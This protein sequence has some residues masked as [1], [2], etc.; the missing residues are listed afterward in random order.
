VPDEL[1]PTIRLR[2]QVDLE[3]MDWLNFLAALR[4]S[5]RVDIPES[6]YEKLVTLDGLFVYLEQRRG[7]ISQYPAQLVRE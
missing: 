6:D 3:S 1:D 2:D 7:P 5:L 4:E